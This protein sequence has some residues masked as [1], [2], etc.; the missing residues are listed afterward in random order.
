MTDNVHE[1]HKLVTE[2]LHKQVGD[3]GD[4]DMKSPEDPQLKK[5]NTN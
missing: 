2:E 4:R 5:L 1:S 3:D